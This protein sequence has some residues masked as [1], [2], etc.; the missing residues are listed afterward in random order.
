MND[1]I[2]RDHADGVI[3]RIG[4]EEVAA[5]VHDDTARRGQGRCRSRA[6]VAGCAIQAVAGH[7]GEDSRPGDFAD[8]VIP[9]VGDVQ[10]AR[11]VGRAGAG[12]IELRQARGPSIA[13]TAGG[14]VSG[15]GGHQGSGRRLQHP[16]VQG[17]DHVLVPTQVE[18][19]AGGA[20]HRRLERRGVLRS[21]SRDARAEHGSDGAASHF[22]N[23]LVEG[24]G[25]HQVARRIDG[26]TAR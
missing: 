8:A 5:A 7:G 24:I 17:I 1:A 19:Y 2:R 4:D 22:A 23:A 15:G 10:V 25:D 20:A 14:P 26:D 13:L 12:Y 16:I 6:F 3:A 9:G 18:A 11:R 21:V